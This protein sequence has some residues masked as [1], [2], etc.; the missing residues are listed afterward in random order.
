[1]FKTLQFVI[2]SLKLAQSL[3]FWDI[4]EILGIMLKYF[5]RLILLILG[6]MKHFKKISQGILKNVSISWYLIKIF[7][8]F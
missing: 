1:M 2:F 6:I 5:K 4:F 7:G 8:R 3:Q